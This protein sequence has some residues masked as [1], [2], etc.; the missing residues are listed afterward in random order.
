MLYSIFMHFLKSSFVA[1]KYT[2][3]FKIKINCCY[4][5]TNIGIITA[6][7]YCIHRHLLPGTTSKSRVVKEYLAIHCKCLND[8]QLDRIVSSKLSDR[9]I[10]LTVLANELRV[11]GVYSRLDYHLDSYLDARSIRDLWSKI[12]LRWVKDYSWNS[13]EHHKSDNNDQESTG[14]S[15]F[16]GIL[17]V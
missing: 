5:I 9:P 17:F 2:L 11:F 4:F 6:C 15:Q 16:T 14:E 13:N 3:H 12:I 8:A 1:K 10:F 7:I